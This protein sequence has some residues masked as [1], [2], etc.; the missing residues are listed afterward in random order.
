MGD[1]YSAVESVGSPALTRSEQIAGARVLVTG[2][3]GLIGSHLVRALLSA[4]A[5]VHI[6][7]LPDPEADSLL[8]TSSDIDRVVVHAGR[9]EDEDSVVRAVGLSRPELVVHLGAQTLVGAAWEDPVRTFRVNVTGTL[10]LLE[11][12]RRANER[13]RAIA[14]ASSD[15]A[16]GTSDRL[17]YVETDPLAGQEP[18]E[19]SKVMTDIVARTYG[20][21][22]GLPTR[23]ARC[24]N[25]YG[26]GDL[27]WSRIVPGTIR[28]LLRKERPILRSD[29][30]PIRDYIHVADV[31]SAYIALL[32]HPMAPGEAFNFSSG[33]RLSVLDVVLSIREAIGEQL[34]PM[35]MKSVH[36]EIQEQYLD[37]TKARTILGWQAHR[38]LQGSLAEVVDWYRE[39]LRTET[40]RG[41]TRA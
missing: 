2:A 16:Y 34:E 13:P 25:V 1:G 3:T 36:G 15:K 41:R 14:I 35:I 4:S 5:I 8:I 32:T 9:L 12:C 30:T 10:A 22:Y 11:A 23:I 20:K 17:P 21:T 18:Y 33:E 31:V 29:G 28:S 7:K 26:S 6:L 39:L 38:R 27:N 40:A 37:S 24:G 19:A